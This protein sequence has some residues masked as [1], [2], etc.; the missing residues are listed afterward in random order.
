MVIWYLLRRLFTMAVALWLIITITFVIMHAVPGGPF[1]S[2]KKLPDA[3]K[4]NLEERYHLNDPL[5]KQYIDYFSNLLQGDLGPS[6]I[7]EHQTVNSIIKTCFPVSATLGSLAIFFSLMVGLSAGIMAALKQNRWVDYLTMFLATLCFSVPSFILSGIL[8]YAFAYQLGWLPAAMWG[9]WQQ[10]VLPTIALS[11]FPTAFIARLMRSSMLEVLR[12]DYLRTAR[13]KGLSE[14]TVVLRHAVRNAILPVVTYMGPMVATIL[15]G[16]FVVE[17]IF[18][19]PGLGRWFV[20]SVINRDYTVILGV[21]VF[22]SV[23]LMLMNLLV[24]LAYTLIDPRIKITGSKE[25]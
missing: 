7:Y 10:A 5:W 12:Q 19:I 24:D 1:A 2:E 4:K 15:T 20:L 13:A 16:S 9:T 23:L 3:I 14:T 17:S 25:V 8:M 22:Y 18:A 6:F 21:T 11:A